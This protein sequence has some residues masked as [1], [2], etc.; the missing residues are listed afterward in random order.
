MKELATSG[1]E[2][3]RDKN[4]PGL[5]E[6]YDERFDPQTLSGEVELWIPVK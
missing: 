3:R 5:I 6:L 1:Y 4:I 2:L